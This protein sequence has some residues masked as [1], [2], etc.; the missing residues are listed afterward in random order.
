MKD[1][2][3]FYNDTTKKYMYQYGNFI[4]NSCCIVKTKTSLQ[5]SDILKEK[6]QKFWENYKNNYD[7]D[8]EIKDINIKKVKLS[9]NF[10]K[11]CN[12]IEERYNLKNNDFSIDLKLLK[13]IYLTEKFNKIVVLKEKNSFGC[14]IPIIRLLQDNK[15]IGYCLPCRKY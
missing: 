13:R 2:R 15:I 12:L 11:N 6:L 3:L 14:S 10:D 9:Y 5:K 1:K 4:T 7:I 8:Y